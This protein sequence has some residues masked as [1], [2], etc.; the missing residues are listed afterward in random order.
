MD[1]L[2]PAEKSLLVHALFA[3][4]PSGRGSPEYTLARKLAHALDVEINADRL[5]GMQLRI[6]QEV[7]ENCDL[8]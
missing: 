5:V 7:A 6:A 1:N 8:A 2:S 3:I 4:S